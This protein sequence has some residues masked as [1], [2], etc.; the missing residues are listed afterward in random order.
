M[1]RINNFKIEEIIKEIKEI[2]SKSIYLYGSWLRC[3]HNP[4]S[5][6]DILVVIDN[7]NINFGLFKKLTKEYP[8]ID[9]TIV[10]EEELKNC[11]HGGFNRFYYF[12]VYYS[13][14]LVYGE[15][16]ISKLYTP[17]TTPKHALWRVQCVAQR[18]RGIKYNK[19][20]EEEFNFWINK[21]KKW[22]KLCICEYLLI[23][24]GIYTTDLDEAIE[25]FQKMYWKI[26]TNG[27]E[28]LLETYEKLQNLFLKNMEE[29]NRVRNGVFIVVLNKDRKI[30]MLERN[31]GFGWEYPKGGFELNETFSECARRELKEETGIKKVQAMYLTPIVTSFKFPTEDMNQ[32]RVYRGIIV[33]TNE[34]PFQLDPFFSNFRWMD[35]EEALTK[36]SWASYRQSLKKLKKWYDCFN[37][38]FEGIKNYFK[39]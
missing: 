25:I 11:A 18:L 12:N 22:I 35:F 10:R 19:I 27:L 1:N 8:K 26:K 32:I 2:K 20:K 24:E 16:L 36:M 21:F 33:H 17:M 14:I 6:I 9:L 3:N 5:D 37:K 34:Q 23:I 15:D 28:Q 13:S 31:D 4:N 7:P 29:K 39:I 38:N 30:L